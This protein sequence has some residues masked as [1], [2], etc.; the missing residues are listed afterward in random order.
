MLS[1]VSLRQ[2]L[3]WMA[4]VVTVSGSQSIS[5]NRAPESDDA[6]ERQTRA[7][8]R[9]G[10]IA[11]VL[12]QTL[13]AGT[14][15]KGSP[16]RERQYVL[17]FYAA[18]GYR[19]A[20]QFG[21]ARDAARV[22]IDRM[23]AADQDGL[24]A[25]DYAP[26]L[27]RERMDGVASNASEF[28]SLDIDLTTALFRFA[29]DLAFGPA[30][31]RSARGL[32]LVGLLA[33][34]RNAHTARQVIDAL[35][36]VHEQYRQLKRALSDYREIEARGGWP[37]VP[38][39]PALKPASPRE[40]DA[41]GMTK[42]S[43]TQGAA[44]G[45]MVRALCGRLAV[46][47]DLTAASSGAACDA[48]PGQPAGY[49][50]AVEAAIQRFQSRH[51]LVVDGIVGPGT[52]AAFNVPAAERVQQIVANMHRWR[53]LPDKL[54]DV[55]VSVNIAGFRLV[56]VEGGR[57]VLSMRVVAGDIDS[58]TP[59]MTDEIDYLE[60]SPYWNVPETITRAELLPRIARNPSYLHH[61]RFE[62][63]DGWDDSARIVD[64]ATIDWE[65]AAEDFPYR[66]RQQ[67]GP[68][69]ALGLVKFM[70]PN[71]RHIYLHDTPSTNRFDE[72]QRA[73]SHGCVRVEDPVA[74][75]AF[76]LRD[77]AWSPDTIRAAMDGEERRIVPLATPVPV[78]LTYFTAWVE[79]DVMQF[80][81][82]L[83]GLDGADASGSRP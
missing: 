60:F 82:D 71:T 8:S 12:Q 53:R 69:N 27:W 73:F 46:T 59:I 33:T 58:P 18:R 42:R 56:A 67:P 2:V 62:V 51:G 80:R 49:N 3:V 10:Q 29:S 13:E 22:L 30:P 54:G 50:A 32:D 48:S 34:A 24:A 40:T 5:S 45:A 83:Y 55:H 11:R 78:H 19:P 41:G 44:E 47:G 77:S 63:V 36:P 75:A 21:S 57:T 74:L 65:A 25:A 31:E 38:E 66:L 15:S 79:D 14:A 35:E 26:S 1:R 68:Q 7:E 64:P 20:W 4:L 72:P 28:V 43:S 39:G 17:F 52:V 81:E 16:P 23:A 6:R 70:F 37:R 9:D 76:L 61:Q